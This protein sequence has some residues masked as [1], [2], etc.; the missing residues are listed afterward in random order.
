MH[1]HNAA[2]AQEIVHIGIFF[3]ITA[4]VALA[5]AAILQSHRIVSRVK[6]AFDESGNLMIGTRISIGPSVSARAHCA[7]R[8][9]V[10]VFHPVR[11]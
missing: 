10:F 5:V 7:D 9:A 8:P 3:V 11:M 1:A 4:Y 2:F 6:T